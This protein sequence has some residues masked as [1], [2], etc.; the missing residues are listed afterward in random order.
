MCVPGLFAPIVAGAAGAGTAGAGA[1]AAA[2]AMTTGQV[3]QLAG[4]VAGIG[5]SIW[6]GVQTNRAAAAQAKAIG[7]QK[8]QMLQL[9]SVEDQRYRA[10]FRRQIGSQRAE[11]AA[12]GVDL[13]SPSAVYLGQT[14]AEEMAFGSAAIR[15][16]G[17]AE[18]VEL[19]GQQRML[20]AQGRNAVINGGF[21]AAADF[22]TAA[23]DIWPELL[24]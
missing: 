3:L 15:Q 23:P 1:A 22:L 9:N 8:Q 20:R 13:G 21:S 5:G 12:R 2:T 19:T 24:A 4:T 10:Q 17:Q 18:A 6:Q 7:E 11:L 14:A 16:G